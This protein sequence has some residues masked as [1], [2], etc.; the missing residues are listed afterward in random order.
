MTVA[1]IKIQRDKVLAAY[2]A[3][4]EAQQFTT[5]GVAGGS[6]Q[7]VRADLDTLRRELDKWEGQ[8]LRAQRRGIRIRQGVPHD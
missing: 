3:A 4:L 7:V 6:R 2:N 8:L 1:E 5:S